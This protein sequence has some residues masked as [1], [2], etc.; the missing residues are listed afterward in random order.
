[1][2]EEGEGGL[3]VRVWTPVKWVAYLHYIWC[4][5]LIGPPDPWS[6]VAQPPQQFL[7]P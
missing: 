6:P 5:D 4:P 3:E 1:M 2:A 7:H